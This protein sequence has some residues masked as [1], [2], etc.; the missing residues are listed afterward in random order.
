MNTACVVFRNY[1]HCLTKLPLQF[2]TQVLLNL[3]IRSVH[4]IEEREAFTS[5]CE[6]TE[7]RILAKVGNY[8]S[9]N[10]LY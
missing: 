7:K 2:A 8:T 6:A 1:L 10:S 9:S 3:L 4:K 5:S